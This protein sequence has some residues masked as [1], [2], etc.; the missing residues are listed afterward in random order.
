MACGP[1]LSVASV[2]RRVRR[3]VASAARTGCGLPAQRSAQRRVEPKEAARRSPTRRRARRGPRV[4]LGPDGRDGAAGRAGVAA[5]RARRR[6]RDPSRSDR[7]APAASRAR[8][9]HAAAGGER[10]AGGRLLPGLGRQCDGR[11]ARGCARRRGSDCD[12]R[13]S[14]RADAAPR[15]GREPRGGARG[16]R[17]TPYRRASP[18][19]VDRSTSTSATSR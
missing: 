18:E 4:Q 11:R 13:L 8:A 2:G 5:A 7:I 12:R 16:P 6:A 17:L 19:G 9:G 15:L 3:F 10:P 14:R 1:F